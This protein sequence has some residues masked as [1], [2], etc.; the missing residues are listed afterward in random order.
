MKYFYY[1]YQNFRSLILLTKL[2]ADNHE[3][4]AKD[5]MKIAEWVCVSPSFTII[6][7]ILIM[8]KKM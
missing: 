2:N 5:Q 8:I 7:S 1:Y 4:N 6:F 3:R